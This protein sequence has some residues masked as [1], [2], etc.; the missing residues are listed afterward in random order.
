M[1]QHLACPT[2]WQSECTDLTNGLPLYFYL[3]TQKDIFGSVSPII[4]LLLT[5]IYLLQNLCPLYIFFFLGSDNCHYRRSS[6]Q[7]PQKL[8]TISKSSLPYTLLKSTFS[9]SSNTTSN[10]AL[11]LLRWIAGIASHCTLLHLSKKGS[12][13]LK[14]QIWL[15]LTSVQGMSYPLWN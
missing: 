6:T 14:K 8:A 13:F 9:S 3:D 1:K 11:I 7:K 10:L 12:I 2:K 5:P 4:K 15:S